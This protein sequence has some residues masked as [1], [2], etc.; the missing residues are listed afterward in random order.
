MA[1]TKDIYEAI[2]DKYHK[3][4]GLL[5]VEQKALLLLSGAINYQQTTAKYNALKEQVREEIE[6]WLDEA[7]EFL[8]EYENGTYTGADAPIMAFHK[9][10]PD[11]MSL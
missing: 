11:F 3:A 1:E 10:L 7:R 5:T 6:E 8:D 2:K 4:P 9:I